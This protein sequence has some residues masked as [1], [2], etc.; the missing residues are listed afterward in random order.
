MV[1]SAAARQYKA[2]IAQLRGLR[3]LTGFVCLSRSHSLAKESRQMVA[4]LEAEKCASAI[5]RRLGLDIAAL[6]R[7]FD[8]EL[9]L[10]DSE[11]IS[12]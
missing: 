1:T 3:V 11:E 9:E 5:A 6:R 10:F 2:S 4:A 8:Q 12:T 7:E